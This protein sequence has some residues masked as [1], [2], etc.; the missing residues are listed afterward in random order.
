MTRR[1]EGTLGAGIRARSGLYFVR[2][3]RTISAGHYDLLKYSSSV[4]NVYGEVF[5]TDTGVGDSSPIQMDFGKKG[6]ILD[7]DFEIWIKKHIFKPWVKKIAKE[8]QE[9]AKKAKKSDRS[10]VI[11]HVSSLNLPADVLGREKASPGAKAASIFS[12][13]SS[14][15]ASATGAKR[16]YRGTSLKVGD[17]DTSIKVEE[18]SWKGSDLPFIGS[19]EAGN[20]EITIQLK[21]GASMGGEKHLSFR[22]CGSDSACAAAR[23]SQC[24]VGNL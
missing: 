6:V 2:G 22:G 3:G 13:S 4:S 1:D 20:P 7:G 15:S 11:D 17:Q 12:S 23:G 24:V 10:K 21:C 19:M 18:V 5:F 14:T 16:K 9:E 8:Q